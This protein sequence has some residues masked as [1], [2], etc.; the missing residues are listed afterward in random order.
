MLP[1]FGSV[2]QRAHSLSDS[3]RTAGVG[4]RGPSCRRRRA[5]GGWAGAQPQ[6]AGRQREG[7]REMGHWLSKYW[8]IYILEIDAVSK[9]WRNIWNLLGGPY[10]WGVVSAT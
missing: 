4:C 6:G 9:Y 7:V 5:V 8:N 3:V 1:Y 2:C 10:V